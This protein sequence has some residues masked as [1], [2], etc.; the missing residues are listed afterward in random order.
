MNRRLEEGRDRTADTGDGRKEGKSLFYFSPL[1]VC[2]QEEELLAGTGPS[3]TLT[4]LRLD[5]TCSCSWS[6]SY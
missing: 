5:S 2:I 1:H 4:L 3:A 6:W